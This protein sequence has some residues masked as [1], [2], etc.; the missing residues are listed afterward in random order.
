MP[1]GGRVWTSRLSTWSVGSRGSQPWS[2]PPS[3]QAPPQVLSRPGR[4]APPSPSFVATKLPER[5]PLRP[6]DQGGLQEGTRSHSHGFYRLVSWFGCEAQGERV[7][8]PGSRWPPESSSTSSVLPAVPHVCSPPSQ[9]VWAGSRRRRSRAGVSG[10]RGAPAPPDPRSCRH[11]EPRGSAEPVAEGG[12]GS[13]TAQPGGEGSERR[14]DD[15]TDIR[16]QKPGKQSGP[17]AAF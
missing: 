1:T 6:E 4:A 3:P 17:P 14:R 12:T 8:Q 10:S 11:G 2:R 9:A 5:G 15:K 16:G 13:V 7:T